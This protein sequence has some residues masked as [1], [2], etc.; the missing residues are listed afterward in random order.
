MKNIAIVTGASSGIGWEFAAQL[1]KEAY[2]EIWLI[3][4]REDKLNELAA[5]LKTAVKIIPLDLPYLLF[6]A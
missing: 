5:I 1:D 2:D 4:R 6:F 3:A